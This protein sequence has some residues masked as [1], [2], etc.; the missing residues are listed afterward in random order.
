MQEEYH[1]RLQSVLHRS[2]ICGHTMGRNENLTYIICPA[3]AASSSHDISPYTLPIPTATASGH[4]AY[5]RV[6]GRREVVAAK[7]V[8]LLWRQ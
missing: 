7:F 8:V 5:D 3:T 6:C 2:F 4:Q 1:Q